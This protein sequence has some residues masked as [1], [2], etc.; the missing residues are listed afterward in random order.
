VPGCNI[1]YAWSRGSAT[2]FQMSR[3]LPRFRTPVAPPDPYAMIRRVACSISP[4]I[5]CISRAY[6]ARRRSGSGAAELDRK[7]SPA[8]ASSTCLTRRLTAPL[9]EV[10]FLG[11]AHD[12]AVTCRALKSDQRGQWKGLTIGASG[13]SMRIVH[14]RRR[15]STRLARLE[16][17][18]IDSRNSV[19]KV[20]GWMVAMRTNPG[21]VDLKARVVRVTSAALFVRFVAKRCATICP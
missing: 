11:G 8:T 7:A 4:N 15:M 13:Y 5:E 21:I 9:G 16:R 6:R 2:W 17:L 10:Q 18:R 20:R 12:P 19:P 3:T 1:L 14:A